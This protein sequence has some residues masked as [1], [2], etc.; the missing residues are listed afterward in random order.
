VKGCGGE[1][2]DLEGKTS[3]PGS[4]PTVNFKNSSPLQEDEQIVPN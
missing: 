1:Q 4:P 3:E 2:A